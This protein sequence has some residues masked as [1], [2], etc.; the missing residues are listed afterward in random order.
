MES[1]ANQ[2]QIGGTHYK[3]SIEPWDAI[4]SWELGYLDGNVVK[5]VARWRRKGGL[6]DLKKAQHYLE[7]LI[8]NE[9]ASINKVELPNSK[10]PSQAQKQDTKIL[11]GFDEPYKSI[12]PLF[13]SDEDI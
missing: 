4:V 9:E 8:E 5:Y 6:A 13:R 2:K 12:L 1:K 7:K 3:T 11:Y 10:L